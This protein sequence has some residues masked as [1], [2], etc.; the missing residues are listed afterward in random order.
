VAIATRRTAFLL[1]QL[2]IVAFACASS[3]YRVERRQLPCEDANAQA[4][5]ALVAREYEITRFDLAAPGGTGIIEGRRTTPD[6]V[7]HGRVRIICNDEV[8]FQPVEGEWFLPDFE[9]SREV[10]YALL[11]M[12]DEAARSDADPGAGT[13]SA[14]GGPNGPARTA[15]AAA[16]AE[17]T[18]RVIVRPLDRF[19]VRKAVGVD[20][21]RRGLLVVRVEI[22]NHTAR[23]YELP[24]GA[25]ALVDDVANRVEPLGAPDIGRIL[26]Q[27]AAAAP[28]PEEDPLPPIDV[29]A[30]TETLAAKVLRYGRVAPGETMEG[31][32]YFPA[33]AYRSARLRLVDT[34]TGETEG[35]VVAF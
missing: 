30:I 4:H 29:A 28:G 6:G 25:I 35:M 11:A 1:L 12:R 22:A 26:R 34:E 3:K 2:V 17:R 24:S 33:A 14:P 13:A 10:Y 31:V 7:R 23:T 32:L 21:D 8:L 19:E 9:F 27:T 15:Q 20:L 5:R 18:L 16:P